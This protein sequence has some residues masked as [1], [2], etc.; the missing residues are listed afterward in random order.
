VNRLKEL[1][2]PV[3][4]LPPDFE[5]GGHL[6]P[7]LAMVDQL[8]SVDNLPRGHFQLGVVSPNRT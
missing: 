6:L 5:K 7:I 4:S 3:K 1:P 8:P 2:D